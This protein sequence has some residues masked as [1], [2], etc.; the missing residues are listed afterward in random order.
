[1]K[2]FLLQTINALPWIQMSLFIILLIVLCILYWRQR[3]GY[4]MLR[5]TIFLQLGIHLLGIASYAAL[6]WIYFRQTTYASLYL[7]P[8]G[9]V[10]LTNLAMGF[11]TI[12]SGW[13]FV[14]VFFIGLWYFFLRR[15]QGAMLDVRD[16]GLF[17]VG[18]IPNGWPGGLLFLAIVFALSVFG[19]ITLVIFRKKKL[20]ERLIIT[21]YIL[22]AAILT[23]ITG[24]YFLALTHLDK[25]RF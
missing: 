6:I 19:M 2:L 1:M 14:A 21:P 24:P 25:I 15:G 7:P 5:R 9:S 10:L 18:A 3:L 23:L 11:T 8:Q 20:T 13:V 16:V 22:P 12:I 4:G 17:M